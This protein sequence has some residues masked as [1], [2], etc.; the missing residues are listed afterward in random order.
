MLFTLLSP[1][2]K[3]Q[4]QTFSNEQ[5]HLFLLLLLLL[6]LMA[7]KHFQLRISIRF[8][9]KTSQFFVMVQDVYLKT[10][11]IILVYVI[12]CYIEVFYITAK[13]NQNKFTV[14]CKKA[15]K[16]F[17]SSIMKN[18]V[19][20]SSRTRLPVKL[21]CCIAFGLTSSACCLLIIFFEIGIIQ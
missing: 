4:I 20:P 16:S 12:K 5:L 3:Y 8:P 15:K 6:I 9:L 2:D 13:K 19:A 7:L 1:K 14:P 11:L 10:L 21:I 18:I 17:A